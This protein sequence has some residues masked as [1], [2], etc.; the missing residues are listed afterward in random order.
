MR[1]ALAAWEEVAK[2]PYSC[3]ALCLYD[4]AIARR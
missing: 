1:L 3:L 2:F 4:L